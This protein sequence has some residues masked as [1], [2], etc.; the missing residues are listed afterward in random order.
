MVKTDVPSCELSLSCMLATVSFLLANHCA[1][2]WSLLESWLSPRGRLGA[3]FLSQKSGFSSKPS[4]SCAILTL[5]CFDGGLA[6][7]R[8]E[9]QR[10]RVLIAANGLLGDRIVFVFESDMMR[11]CSFVMGD[12]LG[13]HCCAS[14]LTRV[15]VSVL[16]SQFAHRLLGSQDE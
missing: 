5:L 4:A 10:L 2:L 12:D 8:G 13:A 14:G 7:D 15:S 11:H 9:R 3:I 16:H 1:A 6:C